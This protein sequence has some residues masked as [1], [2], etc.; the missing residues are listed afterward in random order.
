MNAP[1]AAP[2]MD[3]VDALREADQ[4]L[5]WCVGGVHPVGSPYEDCGNEACRKRFLDEDAQY[6]R[7]DDQ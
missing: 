7:L 2:V 3:L 1:V 5:I 6:V 4:R